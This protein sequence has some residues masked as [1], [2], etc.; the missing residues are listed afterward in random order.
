MFYN[1]SEDVLVTA[2]PLPNNLTLEASTSSSLL[3]SWVSPDNETV[4]DYNLTYKEVSLFI[5]TSSFEH[6]VLFINMACI[7]RDNS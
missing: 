5:F 3:V 6:F 1:D 4:S 7:R 2:L